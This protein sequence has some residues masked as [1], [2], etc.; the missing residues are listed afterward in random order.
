MFKRSDLLGFK[1]KVKVTRNYT[2]KYWYNETNAT[3]HLTS[4]Y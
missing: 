1:F 2:N 3:D 4:M